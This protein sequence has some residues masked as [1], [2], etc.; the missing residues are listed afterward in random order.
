MGVY[1]ES[2]IMLCMDESVEHEAPFWD[3]QQAGWYGAEWLNLA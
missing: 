1:L 2:K 3:L